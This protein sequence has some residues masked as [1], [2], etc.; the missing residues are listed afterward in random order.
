MVAG[1]GRDVVKPAWR[2]LQEKEEKEGGLPP[3]AE[4][5]MTQLHSHM[6]MQATFTKGYE[7]CR[8]TDRDMCKLTQ[9]GRFMLTY[10]HSPCFSKIRDLITLRM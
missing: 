10:A 4:F 7:I 2:I 6:E 1:R 5:S 9:V 8:L 3:G